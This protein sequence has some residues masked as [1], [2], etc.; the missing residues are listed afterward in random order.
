MEMKSNAKIKAVCKSISKNNLKIINSYFIDNNNLNINKIIDACTEHNLDE[1]I[2]PL[3]WRIFLGFLPYN[4]IKSWELLIH[5]SRCQYNTLKD[6]I[7]TNKIK[8]FILSPY[9]KGSAEYESLIDTLNPKDFA[10]LSLIKLDLDRTFQDVPFFNEDRVKQ[11]LFNILFIYCKQN[12][13]PGYQQGMNEILGT[14][15][16]IFQPH[17][18]ITEEAVDTTRSFLFFLIYHTDFFEAD[19]YFVFNELMSRGLNE[20][21]DYNIAVNKEYQLANISFEERNNMTLADIVSSK[22]TELRKRIFRVFYCDFKLINKKVYNM[23]YTLID[24]VVFLLRWI[25]CL[26]SREF[27]IEKVEKIWDVILAYEFSEFHMKRSN[28]L[29]GPFLAFVDY[30]SL[31]MLCLLEKKMN[32]AIDEI[33]IHSMLMHYPEDIPIEKIISKAIKIGMKLNNGNNYLKDKLNHSIKN[34]FN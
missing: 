18:L 8:A 4:D 32:N 10:L 24:P 26:L 19:L 33:T 23:L 20:L 28:K 27:A 6:D 25:L 29:Q 31:A 30:L 21:Y 3:V 15:A 34:I 11:G 1:E 2:R 13:K 5:D 12:H 14:L 22:D 16:Y 17:T 7:I 9:K